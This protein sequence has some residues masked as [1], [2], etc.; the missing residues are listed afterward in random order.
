MQNMI[1]RLVVVTVVL[2]HPRWRAV[3]V[4]LVAAVGGLVE[5]TCDKGYTGTP[6]AECAAGKYKDVVGTSTCT[7]CGRQILGPEGSL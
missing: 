5:A 4:V 2:A 3:L 1:S 6:C 7:D